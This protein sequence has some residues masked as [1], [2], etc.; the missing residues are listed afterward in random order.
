MALSAAKNDLLPDV[1][2]PALV[3]RPIQPIKNAMFEFTK[4]RGFSA[5]KISLQLIEITNM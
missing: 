2:K 4:N 5:A 1:L 3:P